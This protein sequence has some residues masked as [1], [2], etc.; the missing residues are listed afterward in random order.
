[1]QYQTLGENGW[2]GCCEWDSID[3]L[4]DGASLET[5]ARPKRAHAG[6]K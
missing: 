6:K 2:G 5:A 3:W 4:A 1:M